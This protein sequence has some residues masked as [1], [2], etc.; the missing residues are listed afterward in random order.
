MLLDAI[1]LDEIKLG[2][3][4]GE[5]VHGTIYLAT[6][7]V[8]KQYAYKIEKIMESDAKPSFD[9][10]YWREKEFGE[11]FANKHPDH[12]LFLHFSH[13]DT[14]CNHKQKKV[15]GWQH[16]QAFM[17]DTSYCSIK[18]W[19]LVEGTLSDL[20]YNKRIKKN[21]FYDLCIQYVYIVHLMQSAGYIHCDLHMLNVGYVK[22]N[23]KTIT[24]LGHRVRTHG[25]ILQAL[26]YGNIWHKKYKT[27]TP[28]YTDL[29]AIVDQIAVD[30]S[31]VDHL[32]KGCD[33]NWG[34]QM[35]NLFLAGFISPEEMVHITKLFPTNRTPD[36]EPFLRQT[37]YK[38]LYS[39]KWQQHTFNDYTLRVTAPPFLIPLKALLFLVKNINA[40]KKCIHYLV[41]KRSSL[42]G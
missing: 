35:N 41:E 37:L 11:R 3:K 1:K 4:L 5:G 31:K 30:H 29:Y 2:K 26:D 23:K 34:N 12:F 33:W 24:I 36:Q 28:T 6:D 18:L 39:Q 42:L 9:S 10:S 32:A 19:S 38:W 27:P 20:V 13:V 7:S 21:V 22:T 15:P 25:Y 14:A 40:P 16:V 17:D 8:G